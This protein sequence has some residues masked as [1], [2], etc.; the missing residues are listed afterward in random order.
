MATGKEKDPD[1]VWIE[2]RLDFMINM[3]L[4]PGCVDLP[5]RRLMKDDS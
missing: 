3:A 2:E 1:L 5:A 4:H